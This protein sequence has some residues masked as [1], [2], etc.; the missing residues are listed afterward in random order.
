ML[1]DT[2]IISFLC[3]CIK[4]KICNMY[5]CRHR[6]ANTWA[7]RHFKTCTTWWQCQKINVKNQYWITELK[8]ELFSAVSSLRGTNR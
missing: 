2:L 7:G 3:E 6:F 8:I 4:S 1:W 5:I